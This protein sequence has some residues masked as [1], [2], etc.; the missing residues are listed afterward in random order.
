MSKTVAMVAGVFL[1]VSSSLLFFATARADGGYIVDPSSPFYPVVQWVA[2]FW[3]MAT[4]LFVL[5][6]ILTLLRSLGAGLIV[7]AQVP[8]LNPWLVLGLSLLVGASLAN[9]MADY[10][11]TPPCDNYQCVTIRLGPP[12]TQFVAAYPALTLTLVL[13]GVVIGAVGSLVAWLNRSR[14][15]E[16]MVWTMSL[17]PLVAVVGLMLVALWLFPY[18]LTYGH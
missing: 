12:I 7:I 4:A 17:A 10:L 14:L 13:V 5:V 1:T 2:G 11:P 3:N 8:R 16:G 9:I 6:Y 18:P 15:P